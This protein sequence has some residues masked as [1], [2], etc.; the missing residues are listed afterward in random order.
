LWRQNNAKGRK[1][2]E[3]CYEGRTFIHKSVVENTANQKGANNGRSTM[4]GDGD[5]AM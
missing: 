4:K 1:G 3:R 2:R 5:A